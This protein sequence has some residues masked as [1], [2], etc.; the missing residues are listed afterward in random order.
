MRV[1]DHL[2]LTAKRVPR[3]LSFRL[4]AM[5]KPRSPR[6]SQIRY[7]GHSFLVLLNEDVGWR[8]RVSRE[9]ESRELAALSSL[10]RETDVC[11]DVG[12]NIGLYSVVLGALACKGSVFAFDPN[13][14]CVHI[15]SL[16]AWLNERDNVSVVQS[17]VSD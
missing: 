9:F 4:A 13:P 17:A 15:A 14:T 1:L 8:L 12:A 16:N 3:S 7:M 11:V 6:F 5:L 2:A 10:V